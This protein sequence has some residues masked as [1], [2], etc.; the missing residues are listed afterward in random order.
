M[1]SLVKWEE[2]LSKRKMRRE[3]TDLNTFP[4]VCIGF[5][6]I[7]TNYEISYLYIQIINSTGT[8]DSW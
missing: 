4:E 2:E 3:N 6:D 1:G 8:G 7:I 5:L